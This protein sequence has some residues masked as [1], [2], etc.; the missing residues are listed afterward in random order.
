MPFLVDNLK[1]KMSQKI[2]C[3]SDMFEPKYNIP[4]AVKHLEWLN[5]QLSHPLLKAY[6]Y[7][8]GVGFTKRY[9]ES[10]KF[11]DKEYEPFL[12]MD[13]MQNSECR[14]Y[15]KKVLANYVMYKKIMGEEV[16]IVHLFDILKVGKRSDHFP[17]QVR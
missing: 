2:T 17:K 1:T 6:A 13:M 4:Y 3:Y 16:S 8:A 5:K 14:E 9:I 12:S 10:D 15:G 11:T 7:N